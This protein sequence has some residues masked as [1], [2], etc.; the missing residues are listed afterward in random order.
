[1]FILYGVMTFLKERLTSHR[2]N[3]MEAPVSIRGV[4]KAFPLGLV[5]TVSVSGGSSYIRETSYCSIVFMRMH[6]S[7]PVSCLSVYEDGGLG[8]RPVGRDDERAY[9]RNV[10]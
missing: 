7:C 6:R 9:L 10:T 1:M 5:N 8:R 2:L 4:S 3:E